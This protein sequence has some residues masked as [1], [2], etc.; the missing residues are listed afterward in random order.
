MPSILS[1]PLCVKSILMRS[2]SGTSSPYFLQ[3][4]FPTFELF[5]LLVGFHV[6]SCQFI[7]FCQSGFP[8][9]QFPMTECSSCTDRCGEVN[10]MNERAYCSCDAA[11]VLYADC[12]P[13]FNT[14]CQEEFETA[15]V[16]SQMNDGP[17]SSVCKGITYNDGTDNVHYY[18]Q[19]IDSCRNGS[20]CPVLNDQTGLELELVVPVRDTTTGIYY[21]NVACARCNGVGRVDSLQLGLECPN[22]EPI[23][24]TEDVIL[25]ESLWHQVKNC[26]PF[27]YSH[28]ALPRRCLSRVIA[29]CP[30]CDNKDLVKLC[31][32]GTQ[33]YTTQFGQTYRNVYCAV[34]FDVFPNDMNCLPPP[35]LNLVLWPQP[36]SI[37][38]SIEFSN[39]GLGIIQSATVR[40]RDETA[41]LPNGIHCN[42]TVCP[43]GYVRSED[44]CVPEMN[45]CGPLALIEDVELD[46][47]STCAGRCGEINRMKA[48]KLCSCDPGCVVYKDCCPDFGEVCSQFSNGN[49]FSEHP[50]DPRTVCERLMA[51]FDNAT[52]YSEYQLISSCPDGSECTYEFSNHGVDLEFGVPV[53][54]RVTNLYYVNIACARCNYVGDMEA[55]QPMLSCPTLDEFS[56]PDTFE[57]VNTIL[58]ATVNC[59][60]I[61]ASSTP[62]RRCLSGVIDRC[63]SCGNQQLVDKC[64]DWGQSYTSHLSQTYRNIYCAACNNIPINATRCS[65]RGWSANTIQS[66]SFTLNVSVSDDSV[67]TVEFISCNRKHPGLVNVFPCR[68]VICPEGYIEDYGRCYPV[69]DYCNVSTFSEEQVLAECSSCSGRCGDVNNMETR[70]RCSC[71]NSCLLY[72][73]CCPDFQSQ[74]PE[75]Y[76]DSLS[77]VADGYGVAGFQCQTRVAFIDNGYKE[78][79]YL[80]ITNCIDGSEC[81]QS[82]NGEFNLELGLPVLDAETGMYYISLACARCNNIQD[83]KYAPAGLSCSDNLN[84]MNV[85][86]WGVEELLSSVKRCF[87][88]NVFPSD[89]PPRRCYS[90]FRDQ[91]NNCANS[92]IVDRC[93]NS[94]FVSYT[95]AN[96]MV[97]RNMYCAA[98]DDVVVSAIDCNNDRDAAAQVIPG[99]F[100]LSLIIDFTRS[101][102]LGVGSVQVTCDSSRVEMPDGI[103]CDGTICSLGYEEQNGDCVQKAC[104]VVKISSSNF[105]VM[106][107][108]L[109][110]KETGENYYESDF[111]MQNS[112][113]LV[114]RPLSSGLGI[115]TIV[116]SVLS[117]VCLLIRLSLQP[118]YARY[119]SVSGRLQCNLAAALALATLMLLVSPL[120]ATVPKLCAILGAIKAAGYLASHSWMNCVAFD[121]CRVVYNSRSYIQDNPNR[122]IFKY[123]LLGWLVPVTLACMWY[124]LD[125]VVTPG[126]YRPSFGGHSCWFQE[127]M[128][129]ILYLFIPIAISVVLN[130][131]LFIITSFALA[132]SFKSSNTVRKSSKVREYNVYLR[133]FILMG[134]TWSVSFIAVWI[135]SQTVWY[136][137]VVLNA[138]QGVF[139]FLAFLVDTKQC[140][141]WTR[142]CYSSKSSEPSQSSGKTTLRKTNITQQ[143]HVISKL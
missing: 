5:C 134:I 40:C 14:V 69:V 9:K 39:E 17:S 84:Q 38:F 32:D 76:G 13:D 1:R 92:I 80:I 4:M 119:H 129:L 71:D 135:N 50:E 123:V 105:I 44:N 24:H 108:T 120:A 117:L 43:A 125:F 42:D 82:Y 90:S 6:A 23:F 33:S 93:E 56:R 111:V 53:R 132:Q 68:T 29:Q 74:C 35:D 2:G 143:S 78:E 18:Y 112:S 54:D 130:I 103:S 140:F 52:T 20:S 104:E 16:L 11:C 25:V 128:S 62:P 72:K 115:I 138:S 55:M 87:I 86:F 118:F 28:E 96:H 95:Y 113:A 41:I 61:Y 75:Q 79:D 22:Q 59:S 106:N 88:Y 133:L 126:R 73:D 27:F 8:V 77:R 15:Q 141:R 12:C 107:G 46:E 81:L 101:G 21:V 65:G 48:G 85:N 26:I 122:S 37:W 60:V 67:L 34:C 127:T 110:I 19:F 137:F 51:R 70:A 121:T 142:T 91:C 47:C 66:L 49:W 102:E 10:M 99:S 109:T 7:D 57:N 114:C 31:T 100:S 45:Y 64:A 94:S 139:L 136:I 3:K 83:I 63:P 58:S 89:Q 131:I 98:C 97:Y 30:E 116:F 124:I 36:F